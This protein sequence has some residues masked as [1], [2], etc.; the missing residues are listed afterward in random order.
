MEHLKTMNI[1]SGVYQHHI[2]VT[3]V[4]R[5]M[6][7]SE[8]YT[9]NTH[10]TKDILNVHLKVASSNYPIENPLHPDSRF[11]YLISIKDNFRILA[12]STYIYCF[13][14]ILD[15]VNLA[16]GACLLLFIDSLFA[17]PLKC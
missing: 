2:T 11:K 13:G 12:P 3:T 6:E 7:T 17:S 5:D 15:R 10:C 14:K 16:D 8:N 1:N 4:P 9:D